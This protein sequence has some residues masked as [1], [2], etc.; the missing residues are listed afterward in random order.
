VNHETRAGACSGNM[1]Q[2]RL[3]GSNAC[4][5]EFDA[6]LCYSILLLCLGV[7]SCRTTFAIKPLLAE[8]MD[9]RPII[10][11]WSAGNCLQ[12]L[13]KAFPRF[14]PTQQPLTVESAVAAYPCPS[15]LLWCRPL[16]HMYLRKIM[17]PCQIKSEWWC[18]LAASTRQIAELY[19]SSGWSLCALNRAG[20]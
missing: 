20:R 10:E 12:L 11:F 16:K 6:V 17:M 4:Q 5:Y 15:G 2:F 3:S 14:R 13:C 8:Q 18:M 7:P 1:K 19:N 9:F